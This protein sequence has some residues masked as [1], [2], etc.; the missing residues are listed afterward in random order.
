M[1]AWIWAHCTEHT[2]FGECGDDWRFDV[3]TVAE[4]LSIARA[5]YPTAPKLGAWVVVDCD[6]GECATR[7]S[8]LDGAVA[9]VDEAREF[10]TSHDGGWTVERRGGKL[11]DHCPMHSDPRPTPARPV[12]AGVDVTRQLDL[13]GGVA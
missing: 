4:A 3:A 10:T 13:F 5:S 9:G 8:L 1:T 11:V 7:V 2:P 12:P 6:K